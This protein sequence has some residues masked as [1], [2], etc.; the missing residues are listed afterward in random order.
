[1]GGDNEK[2]GWWAV[3]KSL[4]ANLKFFGLIAVLSLVTT[5]LVTV[6]RWFPLSS[7]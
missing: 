2:E 3:H 4:G 5:R 6:G 7:R 1:M